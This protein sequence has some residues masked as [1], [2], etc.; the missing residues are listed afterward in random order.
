MLRV[1]II[2][3]MVDN[4]LSKGQDLENNYTIIKQIGQGQFSNVFRVTRKRDGK[5]LAMK[6]LKQD[7]NEKDLREI[8]LLKELRHPNIIRYEEAFLNNDGNLV[9]LSEFAEEGTLS[10]MLEQVHK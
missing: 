7:Y 6:I 9:I 4:I 8:K 2:K 10:T 1:V 5:T 3:Q